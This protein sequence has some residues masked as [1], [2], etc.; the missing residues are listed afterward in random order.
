MCSIGLSSYSCIEAKKYPVSGSFAWPFFIWP[1]AMFTSENRAS[2]FAV[3]ALLGSAVMLLGVMNGMTAHRLAR[4]RRDA[5]VLILP[6][7]KRIDWMLVWNQTGA[8]LIVDG[9]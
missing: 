8:M 9:K 1:G 5:P 6:I 4:Y 3:V 2:C 7:E